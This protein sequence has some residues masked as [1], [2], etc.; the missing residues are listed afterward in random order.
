M[1]VA[2][3]CDEN[4]LSDLP[5]EIPPVDVQEIQESNAGLCLR[6]GSVAVKNICKICELRFPLSGHLP[7]K[8][9]ASHLVGNS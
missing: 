3:G 2:L 1:Y 9:Q 6:D 8:L 5:A 4:Y 7:E